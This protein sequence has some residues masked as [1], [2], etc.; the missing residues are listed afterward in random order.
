MSTT[1]YCS[2]NSS[3]GI[4]PAT[5]AGWGRTSTGLSRQ[6]ALTSDSTPSA[7]WTDSTSSTVQ[8]ICLGQW[9]YGPLNSGT[10]SGT[11]QPI[12]YLQE[13]V[14]TGNYNPAVAVWLASSTG[15]LKTQLLAVTTG[16]AG[17]TNT[18]APYNFGNLNLTSG[19]AATGDYLILEGGVYNTQLL[20]D[21]GGI[22]AGGGRTVFT[23]SS[24]ITLQTPNN[25]SSS[26]AWVG[27]PQRR[28][29]N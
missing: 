17:V 14:Y 27:M 4:T 29:I 21:N 20:S 5:G 24:N 19:T 3:P 2:S 6:A 22:G 23:F 1:L 25:S 11:V 13:N 7:T 9:I 18:M 8:S 10:I 26:V 15:A 12:L 16:T 28:K